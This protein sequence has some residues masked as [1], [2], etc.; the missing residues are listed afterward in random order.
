MGFKDQLIEHLT[1][2]RDEARE[3]A[4]V[5]K[6]RMEHYQAEM[7]IHLRNSLDRKEQLDL[8][9]ADFTKSVTND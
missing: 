4:G 5:Y 2:E 9:T 1:K 8:L 6:Y 7:Y 3:E